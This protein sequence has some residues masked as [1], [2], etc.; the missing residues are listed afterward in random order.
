[1][2]RLPFA[3]IIA[4]LLSPAFALAQQPRTISTS[5]EALIQVAPDEVIVNV[6]V[7]T[8]DPS[9]DK[10]KEANREAAE[11]MLRALRAMGIEERHIQTSNLE[12]EIR[13]HTREPLMRIEGYL[14]RRAYAIVLKD[15][16]QLEAVTDA[17]LKNGANRLLGIDFRT[18]ELR[19]HRD[20][21][22]KMAIKAAKEKAVA[23]AAELDCRIGAPR[24][25]HEGGG[26]FG[27]V[28]SHWGRG[29]Y[30]MSQNTMQV[31]GDP[32][33]GGETLPLGQVGIRANV[34]V[35]FD[36]QPQ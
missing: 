5:G 29:G 18:T 17:A 6:G 15:P 28:G 33:S 25:I 35:T 26:S 9:L 13:Y 2:L 34:S 14:A 36:L 11:R 4:L 12:L 23:L 7:E 32:G 21:A 8:F 10:S 16:K 19:K 3:F 27:Y 31:V 20:E 24:S 30:S 22:R 1:M